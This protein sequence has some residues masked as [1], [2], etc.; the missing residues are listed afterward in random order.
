MG[1]RERKSKAADADGKRLGEVGM[2]ETGNRRRPMR[3]LATEEAARAD[4]ACASRP[5]GA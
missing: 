4:V 5:N 2:V 1:P 3:F